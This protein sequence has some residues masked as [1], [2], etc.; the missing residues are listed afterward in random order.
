MVLNEPMLPGG[1]GEP[2]DKPESKGPGHTV[3]MVDKGESN[4]LEQRGRGSFGQDSS[5]PT[6]PKFHGASLL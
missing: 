1:P 2:R 5:F 4:I 3:T 6:D